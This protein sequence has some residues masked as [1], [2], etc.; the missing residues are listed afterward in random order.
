MELHLSETVNGL[1]VEHRTSSIER[2]ILTALRLIYFSPS[3]PLNPTK[4]DKCRVSI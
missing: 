4:A 3:E 2:P 1:N